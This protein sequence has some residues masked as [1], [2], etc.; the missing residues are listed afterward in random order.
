[1][2]PFTGV[3]GAIGALTDSA[4][5]D[6]YP[7]YGMSGIA[8]GSD[9]T[10]YGV[11][12]GNSAG[13]PVD[14][15]SQFATIDSSGVVTVLGPTEDGS[16]NSYTI[17]D[18]KV[19]GGTVF[20]WGYWLTGTEASPVYHHGLVKL[21]T[22]DGTVTRVGSGGSDDF[23]FAGL[24]ANG[25]GNLFL[26]EEGAGSDQDFGFSGELDSVNAMTGALTPTIASLDWAYAA[27]VQSMEYVGSNLFALVD[28]GTYG[29]LTTDPTEDGNPIPAGVT[30][31]YINTAAAGGSADPYDIPLFEAPAFP[32]QQ[33]MSDGM[34]TV[35]VA[36]P[37]GI[38]MHV[39]QHLGWYT[40]KPRT[41]VAAH[42]SS[43]TPRAWNPHGVSMHL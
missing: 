26:A 28:E 34:A 6:G 35:P 13:D 30:Y 27:P 1:M 32:G 17:S 2:D 41:A 37:G 40:P 14:G 5:A 11:T 22:T 7:D 23:G 15:E 18:I 24:A 33:S 16:G 10:L 19:V 25:S 20:G 42:V 4:D 39:P 43:H 3:A 31:T 38:S 9:G 36:A 8:F 29:A 21:S 12:T